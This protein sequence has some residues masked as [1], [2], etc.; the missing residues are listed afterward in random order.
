MLVKI[1][2]T[3][4][5]LASLGLGAG[6]LKI[7]LVLGEPGKSDKAFNTLALHGLTYAEKNLGVEIKHLEPSKTGTF[8]S[9]HRQLAKSNFDLVIGIGYPQEEAVKTVAA[10]YPKVKFVIIDGDIKLPNVRSI[11]FEEQQGAFLVGHL[12]AMKSKKKKIG[13]LGADDIPLVRRFEMGY[14][15]GAKHFDKTITVVES[16]LPKGGDPWNNPAKAKAATIELFDK[17]ADIVFAVAGESNFGVF[18]A[19]A[20]KKQLAI[21][22]DSNQ[23]WIKPGVILT[24]MVKRVDTAI[25]STILDLKNS[26]FTAGYVSYGLKE[27]A[28][29]IAVDKTNEKLISKDDLKKIDRLK[30]EIISKKLNVPDFYLIPQ[31]KK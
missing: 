22:V 19:A 7:G 9:L 1:F 24:S 2:F 3:V 18:D 28:L 15:A 17:G 4:L 23:N 6:K 10:Q 29:E 16:I 12:A 21:G 8:E 30:A 5:L 27:G 13:F 14:S 11:M 25:Y 20:E 26:K 31:K